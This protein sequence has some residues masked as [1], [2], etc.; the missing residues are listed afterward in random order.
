VNTFATIIEYQRYDYITYYTVLFEDRSDSEAERFFSRNELRENH[1]TALQQIARWLKR[2]GQRRKGAQADFFRS[3][4]GFHELPPP[5]YK[6]QKFGDDTLELRLFCM[7][8]S[9]NIVIL[10]NGGIKTSEATQDSPDLLPHF[11]E[12]SKLTKA[13]DQS[14]ALPHPDIKI[15]GKSLIGFE[16]TVLE[17]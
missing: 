7:R 6:L 4:Q 9:E 11:R 14:L 16:N 3:V 12:A 10:F 2:I 5:R 17:I 1:L 13:I 8:L 15:E